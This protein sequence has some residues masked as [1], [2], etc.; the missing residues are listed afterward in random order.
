MEMD[1]P[2]DFESEDPFLGSP[3]PKKRFSPNLL[4]SSF[5]T[6]FFFIYEELMSVARVYFHVV[7][8]VALGHL[9]F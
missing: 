9:G 6:T 7:A 1:G 4:F 3:A 5:S 2:L 8:I